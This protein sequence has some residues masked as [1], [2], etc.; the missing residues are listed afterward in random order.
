M[1]AYYYIACEDCR[2]YGFYGKVTEEYANDDCRKHFETNF[3]HEGHTI[4]VFNDYHDDGMEKLQG[5][6]ITEW[7]YGYSTKKVGE[8][9]KQVYDCHEDFQGGIA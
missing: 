7:G 9:Y 6:E 2:E 5:N 8:P 3:G 1:G 4:D